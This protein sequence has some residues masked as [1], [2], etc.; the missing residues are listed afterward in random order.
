MDKKRVTVIAVAGAF[1]LAVA[2]FLVLTFGSGRDHTPP[3]LLPTEAPGSSVGEEH[4]E[5]SDA[6]LDRLLIQVDRRTVRDVVAAM[7][8]PEN[9][10][11]SVTVTLFWEDRVSA[12]EKELWR[13]GD[14]SRVRS[15][16]GEEA[17]RN[18]IWTPEQATVWYEGSEDIWS[19]PPGEVDADDEMLLY[20]YE[21]A[22]DPASGTIL[23]AEY[24]ALGEDNCIYVQ[25]QDGQIVTEL[26]V[27]TESGLLLR[28]CRWQGG[29]V[30]Y[31][32]QLNSLSIGTVEEE[33]F[34]LP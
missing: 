33:S 28:C 34:R 30:I 10:Y 7:E 27:G 15:Q 2:V 22:A 23:Q 1:I 6:A 9:Y 32:M 8:R 13:S 29:A 5:D 20:P 16:R 4:P 12:T 31:E 17:A 3:V 25:L 18:C 24:T 26:W 11:A 21:L 19:G 14:T